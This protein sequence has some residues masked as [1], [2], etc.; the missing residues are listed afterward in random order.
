MRCN[1]GYPCQTEGSIEADGYLEAAAM[2]ADYLGYLVW[3]YSEAEAQ[4]AMLEE[5]Y[6]PQDEVTQDRIN[7][8]IEGGGS[9]LYDAAATIANPVTFTTTAAGVVGELGG[10]VA[11]KAGAGFFASLDAKGAALVAGGAGVLGYLIYRAVR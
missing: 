8:A 6:G 4:A 1:P 3:G 5:H 10:E 7:Q 9:V 2:G 11:N